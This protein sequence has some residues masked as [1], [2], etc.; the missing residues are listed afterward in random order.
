LIKKIIRNIYNIIFKNDVSKRLRR[1]IILF[2]NFYLSNVVVNKIPIHSF[3]KLYYRK[4]GLKIGQET[5]IYRNVIITDPKKLEIKRNTIIGF[6]AHLQA[7]GGISIGKNVNF[8]S[9][10]K[11]W[12]GS[13]DINSSD[14]SVI[15]KP[16]KIEDYVWISTGVTILQGVTIGKGAVI[17]AGSVVMKNV[18]PYA[19]IGGNPGKEIGMRNKNLNYNLKDERNFH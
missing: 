7:T 13:H 2:F 5:K 12:T 14:F 3:R 11:I 10:S 9:Y 16:V 18:R 6:Y 15:T 8:G 4:C 17:M 19:I 1:N